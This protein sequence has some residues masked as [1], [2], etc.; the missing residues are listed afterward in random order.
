MSVQRDIGEL[1]AQARTTSEAIKTLQ[2]A[3][4][5]MN[6]KMWGAMKA[7]IGFL[8]AILLSLITHGILSYLESIK[9]N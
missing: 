4:E 7:V 6:E 3:M 5:K 8:A 9:H 2:A 1:Q